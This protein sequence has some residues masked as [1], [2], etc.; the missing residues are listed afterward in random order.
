[1]NFLPNMVKKCQFSSKLIQISLILKPQMLEISN[2]LYVVINNMAHCVIKFGKYKKHKFSH[3]CCVYRPKNS[4]NCPKIS[5]FG[6]KN[7][8]FGPKLGQNIYITYRTW[9]NL[10]GNLISFNMTC[11]R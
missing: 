4:K 6:P 2:F 11:K 3:L 7:S 8:V 5:V 9:Y 10:E 1:M